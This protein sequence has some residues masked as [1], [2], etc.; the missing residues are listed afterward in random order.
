[1][2]VLVMAYCKALVPS[3]YCKDIAEL[4]V[5]DVDLIQCE[6]HTDLPC[7]SA[8]TSPPPSH[9]VVYSPPLPPPMP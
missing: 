2:D 8:L 3:T 1:M 4:D 7:H 6:L 9:A 5:M